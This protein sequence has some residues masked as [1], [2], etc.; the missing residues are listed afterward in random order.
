MYD[1]FD[2]SLNVT[3]FPARNIPKIWTP[4]SISDLKQILQ[5]ANR[6]RQPIYPIST[7]HNWGLGSKLPV[8]DSE[9]INLSRLN[10]IVEV[11]EELA[12]A[13]IQPGVTQ[14]QL[15][16]YLAKNHTGLILNVT[17]SDAHSSILAN[18]IERGSGKN[19]YS[20]ITYLD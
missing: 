19:S 10:K 3:E 14:K 8:V 15:S 4:N 20:E 1:T 2:Y 7:G 12:Y 18:A 16:E 13:R 11:N 9:L 5:K 17:G 6:E